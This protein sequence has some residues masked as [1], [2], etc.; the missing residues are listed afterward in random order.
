MLNRTHV[1]EPQAPE[2]RELTPEELDGIAGGDI[3]EYQS[4]SSPNVVLCVIVSVVA[5]VSKFLK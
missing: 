2:S 5:S 1:E 4:P 3:A